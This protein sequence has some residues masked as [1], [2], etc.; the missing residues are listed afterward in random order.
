MSFIFFLYPR[1]NF[2]P[3]L[4]HPLGTA[5]TDDS[6]GGGDETEYILW[7]I[8]Q[9]EGSSAAGLAI[10]MCW[11]LA[12]QPGEVV[13]LSWSQTDFT[14]GVLHLPNRDVPMGNRM[15]RLLKETWER[16]KDLPTDK[17]FVAPTTG[18]PMDQSRLSV[19]SRTAM[20]RGGL[21]GFSLR[22]LSAW[23]NAKRLDDILIRGAEEHG[24]LVRDTAAEL[25]NVTPRTAWEYLTRL[26]QEGQLTKVGIRYYPA[27]SAIPIENQAGVLQA[28]LTEHGIAGRQALA[29]QLGIPP[30]QATHILQGMVA[31]GELELVGK[32]YRLPESAP[33]EIP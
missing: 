25:L 19:V 6:Q 32:R 11:K 9:Q 13:N 15:R 31:R 8:V 18:N 12:M 20:I 28:Y 4:K 14:V 27:G 10:W 22:S 2:F 33:K 5:Q 7:R 24:Y 26:N 16:Q 29:K 1:Q 21:E 3:I 30:H 17:V 23:A